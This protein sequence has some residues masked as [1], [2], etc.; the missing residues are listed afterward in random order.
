MINFAAK[1]A[2]TGSVQQ[3]LNFAHLK[4]VGQLNLFY[5]IAIIYEVNVKTIQIK[6]D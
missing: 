2:Q 5:K 1:I 3:L 6:E 4:I